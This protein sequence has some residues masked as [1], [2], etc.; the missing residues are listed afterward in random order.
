MISSRHSW[1]ESLSWVE[2]RRCLCVEHLGV[3]S[4]RFELQ[5]VAGRVEEEHR[6]LLAL[7][8]LEA[9][10]GLDDE[11]GA[12]LAQPLGEFLERGDRQDQP[13]VRHR[14]V[15]AV[16]RVVYAQAALRCEV[17]DELVA[18]QIPVHPGVRTAALLETQHVAVEAT[19]G[20]QVVD[21]HG[22]VESRDRGLE[23]AH[24]TAFREWVQR[25]TLS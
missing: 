6:A 1:V 3:V 2:K 19:C 9:D 13:E 20:G 14:D 21:R 16:D 22:Q 18:V 10:V 5:G 17:R 24:D 12:C 11:L 7:L 23:N 8:A 25:A 4:E 15:V